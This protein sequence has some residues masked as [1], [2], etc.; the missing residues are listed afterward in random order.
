M[1]DLEKGDR[2]KLYTLGVIIFTLVVGL[3][4]TVLDT[5]DV[6]DINRDGK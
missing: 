5:L 1:S 2:A 4:M 6:V 3:C